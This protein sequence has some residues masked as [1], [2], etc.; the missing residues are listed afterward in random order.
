MAGT[1][2][3]AG[4]GRLEDFI[5]RAQKGRK[6]LSLEISLRKETVKRLKLPKGKKGTHELET[7]LLIADYTFTIGKRKH[8]VSKVYMFAAEE[9]SEALAN[10][11][12]TIANARLRMDYDR[13]KAANIPFEEK[14]F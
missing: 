13:L 11:N 9:E 1:C 12:R 4:Y 8:T 5:Q 10:E 14:F 7:Y 3:T 6:K 2:R